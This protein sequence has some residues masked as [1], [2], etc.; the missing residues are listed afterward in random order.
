MDLET[1]SVS[2]AVF[3]TILAHQ[4]DSI[5]QLAIPL[6]LLQ[7]IRYI[8][9]YDITHRRQL[10]I[11]SFFFFFFVS[12][13]SILFR[14]E[15]SVWFHQTN[16]SRVQVIF[17]IWMHQ[18]L[19]S[20]SFFYQQRCFSS[21]FHSIH[22]TNDFSAT[23]VCRIAHAPAAY[24]HKRAFFFGADHF[25]IITKA[26]KTNI[27]AWQNFAVSIFVTLIQ[28]STCQICKKEI[29]ILKKIKWE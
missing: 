18:T 15:K 14:Y 22:T 25:A 1:P 24:L 13:A 20:F 23:L 7:Y 10:E 2:V 11:F 27:S 12:N 19:N 17:L 21:W 9:W 8:K 28:T 26:S 4:R 3:A 5:P 29:T 16:F 6:T